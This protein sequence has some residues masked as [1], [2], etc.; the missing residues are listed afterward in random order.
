MSICPLQTGL[1]MDYRKALLLLVIKHFLLIAI[2][3]NY[4]ALNVSKSCIFPMGRSGDEKQYRY[5]KY[6]VNTFLTPDLKL[7]W[8]DS[9]DPDDLSD[10][11][12][13][14]ELYL[15]GRAGCTEVLLLWQHGLGVR[16]PPGHGRLSGIRRHP[17]L[18]P[19]AGHLHHS[20]RSFTWSWYKKKEKLKPIFHWNLPL[21]RLIFAYKQHEIY[22]KY[23][24]PTPEDQTPPIFH[25]K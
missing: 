19:P 22:M 7:K 11:A 25:W 5:P 8:W 12:G 13:G 18:L 9:G 15:P 6:I 2:K 24:W 14:V 1:P 20:G 10:P 17:H 23:T 21:R 4:I 3:A 16:R